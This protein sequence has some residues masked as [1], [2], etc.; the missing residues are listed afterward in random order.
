KDPDRVHRIYMAGDAAVGKTSF[1]FRICKGKFVP[2]LSST[3]DAKKRNKQT[4]KTGY[5]IILNNHTGLVPTRFRAMTRTYFRRA[6]GVLLLYDVTYER[7]FLNVRDWINDIADGAA[8]KLPIML[9]GN[10]TDLRDEMEK[11]GRRVVKYEDGLR[12]SKEIDALFIETSAKDGN[13]ITEAVI[14]L[15]RLLRTNQDLEVKSVGMQIHNMSAKKNS[16]S[17]CS[18]Q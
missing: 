11:Q 2:N 18:R 13:N 17:C 8:K 14:E 3:L 16:S 10:K 4:E 12:L 1:V 5:A 6:D 9:V 15:T 7:S